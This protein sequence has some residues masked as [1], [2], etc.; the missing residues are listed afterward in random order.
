MGLLIDLQPVPMRIFEVVKARILAN[1]EKLR[2]RLQQPAKAPIVQQG[3]VVTPYPSSMPTQIRPE[4]SAQRG[5]K[6]LTIGWVEP[7]PAGL[8]LYDLAADAT[9]KVISGDGSAAADLVLPGHGLPEL[10]APAEVT[11]SAGWGSWYYQGSYP[12]LDGTFW[13]RSREASALTVRPPLRQGN[14]IL[15]RVV[16]PFDGGLVVTLLDLGKIKHSFYE[17]QSDRSGGLGPWAIEGVRGGPSDNPVTLYSNPATYRFLE[18]ETSTD[19]FVTNSGTTHDF[20]VN[21]CHSFV[22]KEQMVTPVATPETLQAAMAGVDPY[23]TGAFGT[24]PNIYDL[25]GSGETYNIHARL[26]MDYAFEGQV[27]NEFRV[28]QVWSFSGSP[29]VNAWPLLTVPSYDAY[30]NPYGGSPTNERIFRGMQVAPFGIAYIRKPLTP[31]E[32][33]GGAGETGGM[34]GSEVA[35]TPFTYRALLDQYSTEVPIPSQYDDGGR[36]Q[37]LL[38]A[39]ALLPSKFML[40]QGRSGDGTKPA[41]DQPE[42]SIKFR[43]Y[44]AGPLNIDPDATWDNLVREGAPAE[45]GQPP[46]PSLPSAAGTPAVYQNKLAA[47]PSRQVTTTL[48]RLVVGSTFGDDAYCLES[49]QA[50]GFTAEDLGLPPPAEPAP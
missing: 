16:M 47:Q 15:R 13:L 49:L 10:P 35:G 8:A 25:Y 48:P 24:T 37:A 46:N 20:E 50:L 17:V 19:V 18:F 39:M 12:G 4:P 1:R 44:N 32:V 30:G 29:P 2:R 3:R 21:A 41:Y 14:R 23:G 26:A 43:A 11:W 33:E 28:R 31:A 27:Y 42:N 45:P 22:V 5:G 38:A 36:I 7:Q 6:P 40:I 9:I 34:L